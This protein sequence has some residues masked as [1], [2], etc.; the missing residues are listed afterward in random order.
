MKSEI[1]LIERAISL[2]KDGITK[3]A[4]AIQK[5]QNDEEKKEYFE[6]QLEKEKTSLTELQNFKEEESKSIDGIKNDL[7]KLHDRL[8]RA[9][10]RLLKLTN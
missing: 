10:T 4:L 6:K 2:L 8:A 5:K 1:S 9:E 3:N 7:L